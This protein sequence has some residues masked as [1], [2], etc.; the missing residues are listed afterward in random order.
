MD[1]MEGENGLQK[2]KELYDFSI[3]LLNDEQE[4]FVR[5]DEKASRYLSVLTLL[6]GLYV[7]FAQWLIAEKRLLRPASYLDWALLL[8]MFLAFVAILVAW[9]LTFSVLRIHLLERVVLDQETIDYFDGNTLIDVYYGTA[10]GL[11]T[12][13]A[14]NAQATDRKSEKL[15]WSYRMI[16]VCVLLLILLSILYIAYYQLTGKVT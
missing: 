1:E 2:Y 13:F 11:A 3:K 6:F 14:R 12:A 7:F 10:K 5:L 8:V 15:A 9:Y 16:K 4:R